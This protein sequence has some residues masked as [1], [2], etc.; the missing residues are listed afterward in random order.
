MTETTTS[1]KRWIVPGPGRRAHYHSSGSGCDWQ[2]S[3]QP[4]GIQAGR[5][6]NYVL[7]DTR[8]ALWPAA[9]HSSRAWITLRR[10]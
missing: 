7:T 8:S 5:I 6:A 4:G 1:A 10:N 3:R 2:T 9:A